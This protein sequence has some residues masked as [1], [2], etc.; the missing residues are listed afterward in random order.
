[1]TSVTTTIRHDNDSITIDLEGDEVTIAVN[2]VWAGT[3]T[4]SHSR[5]TVDDCPAVLGDDAYDAIDA[6]IVTALAEKEA[7]E[8]LFAEHSIDGWSVVDPN[9]GRWWPNDAATEEIDASDDPE[10]TALD[11]CDNAPTRGTWHD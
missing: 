5:Q 3:G 2:N 8:S 6:A 10:Q 4:W 9:G 1:M 11:I 7:E